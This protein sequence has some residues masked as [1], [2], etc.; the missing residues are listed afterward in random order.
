MIDLKHKVLFIHVPRTGGS[1]FCNA[2]YN[3]M[4]KD[5]MEKLIYTRYLVG[6]EC[7]LKHISYHEYEAIYH[8]DK[9]DTFKQIC[10]IRNIYDLI[11]SVYFQT[12]HSRRNNS[13]FFHG[14]CEQHKKDIT[15][16]SWIQCISSYVDTS[17]ELFRF[18]P[19]QVMKQSIYLA[20]CSDECTIINYEDYNQQIASWYKNSFNLDVDIQRSSNDKLETKYQKANYPT[21][22]PIDYREMYTNYLQGQVKELYADDITVFGFKF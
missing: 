5:S 14:W 13:S 7:A 4:H 20:G 16:Q 21:S 1:Y 12:I 18:S 2:Y 3:Y 17:K 22:R 9:L 8:T 10:I 6:G 19:Y 11:V 15:F